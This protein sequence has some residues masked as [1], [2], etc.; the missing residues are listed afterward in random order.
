[1]FRTLQKARE[2]FTIIELL[3]VIAIIAILAGLVL[4]NFQGA[5]AKA[6]D[7]QRT[8]DINNLHSKLE[9]KYNDDGFYPEAINPEA[10]ITDQFPGI[11]PGSAIDPNGNYIANQTALA[12]GG[13]WVESSPGT[14]STT[15]QYHYTP[16]DCSG[17]PA[18]C[19][20]YQLKAGIEQPSDT[21]EDPYIK[22]GLNNN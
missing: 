3:I 4:N 5:Q 12:A 9:E 2:G 6:R 10:T 7:Q 13:S 19:S 20:D 11:D 22:Y 21:L 16:R 1:M 18:E 17:T 8:T 15:A 14:A